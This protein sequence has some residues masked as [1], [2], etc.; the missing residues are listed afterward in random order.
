MEAVNSYILSVI[1][2]FLIQVAWLLLPI[3]LLGFIISKINKCF[4]N[5]A[6]SSSMK[7]CYATG[8]IG[9]PIHELSHA[10]M[11]VIFRHKIVEIKLF[12][13]GSD[14]GT[15]G[16]VNHSY[17]PKSFYQRIGNFFIGIAPILVGSLVLL[18]AMWLFVPA[19]TA[20]LFVYASEIA[21]GLSFESMSVFLSMIVTFFKYAIQPL[22]WVYLILGTAISL[23]MNLSQSDIKGAK[24]GIVLI[25]VVFLSLNLLLAFFVSAQTFITSGITFIGIILSLIMSLSL[26]FSLLM[27][28]IMAF[29]RK[30]ICRN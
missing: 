14:D 1:S 13:I 23:H 2:N 28:V 27:L 20:E 29:I 12:Q 25:F 17:N 21:E 9:T 19:M 18:F 4:Y 22:W 7:I 15:L 3:I 8:F 11:C 16:Y 30:V 5:L 6:G 10:L 24:T 26:L